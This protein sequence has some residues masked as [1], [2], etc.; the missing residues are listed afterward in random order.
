M[1][2]RN[3][4]KDFVSVLEYYSHALHLLLYMYSEVIMQLQ[5]REHTYLGKLEWGNVWIK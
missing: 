1:T 5:A 4:L 3:K 2:V